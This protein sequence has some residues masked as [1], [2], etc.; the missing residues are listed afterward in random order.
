MKYFF[1]RAQ[2]TVGQNSVVLHEEI[3][4]LALPPFIDFASRHA[5]SSPFEVFRLHLP[6]Q[7]PVLAQK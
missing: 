5:R 4:H 3:S 1:Q 6:D 7:E 2:C